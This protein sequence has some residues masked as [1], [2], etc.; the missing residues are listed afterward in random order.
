MQ[1]HQFRL[2]DRLRVRW[3]EIDAQQIV[4]NAHYLMYFDTAVGAYW[5]AMALP[6]AETMAA[7]GGDLFVR[8]ASLEYLGSARYDDRLDVGIRCGR[9]GNSSM[10]FAAAVFRGDVALVT[11]ELVYV[12]ADP[13]AQGARPVPA[14]LREVLT[15]FEAGL[16]MVDVRLGSWADLGDASRALRDEVFVR[17]QGIAAPLQI[18]SADAGGV[19]AVAFNR[20][21]APVATGRLLQQAPGVARLGRMAVRA[22]LRGSG[23][24][25]QLLGALAT[26]ARQRGDTELVAHAQLSAVPFYLAAG[27]AQRGDEFVEAGIAH[28][29]VVRAL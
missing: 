16:A 15:A 11:G 5:R 24:G 26:A 13:Q 27:F 3:A 9:V 22:P 28:V 29:E 7:L 17:E 2:L 4:F 14:A 6:Y 25:R 23:V 12:F 8:K 21:G 1:R 19:H 10:H 20:V 18:D